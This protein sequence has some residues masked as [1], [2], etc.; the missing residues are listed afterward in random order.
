[1]CTNEDGT[2]FRNS[3]KSPEETNDYWAF[4]AMRTFGNDER[5]YKRNDYRC[6]K[7]SNDE[8]PEN[9]KYYD[10]KGFRAAKTKEEF[11]NIKGNNSIKC[12]KIYLTLLDLLDLGVN[13]D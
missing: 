2:I 1:M 8:K 4:D 7:P 3:S 5:L 12:F 11:N 13:F 9:W 10:M 6:L